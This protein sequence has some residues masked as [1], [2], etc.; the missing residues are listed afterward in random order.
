VGHDTVI[1]GAG[2]AGCVLAARWSER[3]DR[4]VVLLEAGPDV[5][6]GDEPEAIAGG[7][8]YEALAE[9][10]RTWARLSV[11]R[12]SED[13]GSP[14]RRGRGTGGSSS[15]HAMLA[16]VADAADY[17]RWEHTHG[18][19][20]WGWSALEPV[21]RRLAVP[22]RQVEP[23]EWG[24]L[25]RAIV[26]AAAAGSP[27]R[28]APAVLTQSTP[29]RR[30]S[31]ATAYLEPARSRPN[32][33]VQ[34]DATVDRVLF[35]GRRAV[36]VALADG[37]TVRAGEVILAAGAVHSPAIL[38]RSGVELPGIGAGLQDHPSC[39]VTLEL[40]SPVTPT[41]LPIGVVA[42]GG[43]LQ[44]LPFN[45][46]GPSA[47]GF[48]LLSLGLM[49][50]QSRGR[51]EVTSADPDVDPVLWF[52]P[53]S[54]DD[55]VA[56]MVE[57]LQMVTQL[58]EH[59]A[60]ADVVLA[61]YADD[62]GTPWS[63]VASLPEALAHW[64]RSSCGSYMHAAGTCRMGPVD[65]PWSVVDPWCRVIG[66]DGLSVCD[67]SVFPELPAANPQLTVYAV[68]ERFADLRS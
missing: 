6:V 46:L 59:P 7:S 51:V 34:G 29:G 45:H 17:D 65:D 50:T 60:F 21:F 54:R 40:R 8:F 58:L 49:R 52:D 15:V 55:D 13:A 23:A 12:S 43:D 36:G 3:S 18:C 41:S 5:R 2:T 38:L 56:A 57:G 62:Q 20:G 66:Y 39:S 42:A 68:A 9:P 31:A 35:D 19:I 33:V 44:L 61:A 32:L 53:W 10:G 11:R 63:L 47:P 37:T 22:T 48:A 14:Y 27:W 24:P 16:A 28:V 64:L 25:D 26:A 30:A 4:S 1:V 67:A